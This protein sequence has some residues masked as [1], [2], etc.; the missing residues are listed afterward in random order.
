MDVFECLIALENWKPSKES[1]KV[2]LQQLWNFIWRVVTRTRQSQINVN[3]LRILC[4]K[5]YK[6]INNL[7]PNFMRDLFSWTEANRLVREKNVINLNILVHNQVT[8]GSKSLRA[9]GPKVWNSL[10]YHIKSSENLE[11]F[12]MIIKHWSRTRSHCKVCN[13]T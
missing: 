6:T 11:S 5:I 12:K 2:S 7:N 9:F 13:A 10:P 1:S 3:R 8:F 4:A